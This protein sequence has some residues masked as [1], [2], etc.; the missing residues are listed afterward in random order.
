MREEAW[1]DVRDADELHDVL[2]TLVALPA[3]SFARPD[4]QGG[5]RQMFGD[6]EAWLGHFERFGREGRAAVAIAG[7]N[8]YW[9][10]AERAKTFSV[11]FPGGTVRAGLAEVEKAVPTREEALLTL[12]TGW[13]AHL[14]PVTALG[15]G[16]RLGIPAADI[17]KGLLRMEASGT[18]LR[19]NFS[20]ASGC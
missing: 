15:L 16:E 4:S 14:G 20:G 19:G 9:V 7:D 12:V 8:A 1:P 18:V 10:A 13:M 6:A 17:S 2:H 3:G 5:C 11:L